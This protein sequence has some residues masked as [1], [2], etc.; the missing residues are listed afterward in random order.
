MQQHFRTHAG[1]CQAD[2]M[3]SALS[4]RRSVY[5]KVRDVSDLVEEFLPQ[6]VQPVDTIVKILIQHLRR[7]AHS[8]DAGHILCAGAHSTLLSAAEDQVL[9][10]HLV[11]D[12]EETGSLGR[13]DLVSADRQKV[14][15]PLLGIDLCLA[16]TLHRVHMK[17]RGRIFCINALRDLPD[18]LYRAN[19]IIGVHN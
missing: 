14:D 4:A 2:D 1:H 7:K 13:V 12:I 8:R 3:R 16:K 18:R 17:E 11:A 9:H 5:P 10:L 19:L 6:S 15:P